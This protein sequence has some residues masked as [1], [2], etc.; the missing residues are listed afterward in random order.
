MIENLRSTGDVTGGHQY[1]ADHITLRYLD[2]SSSD[3]CFAG[4]GAD[5]D[6]GQK[7]IVIERNYIHDCGEYGIAARGNATDWIV[8]NNRFTQITEDYI[9]SSSPTGW[10]VDHNV[11]GPGDFNRPAGY[12]GHPDIWQTLDTGTNLTFTNNLVKDT[13]QSLGFI[14]G[15]T[16]GSSSGYR[17]VTI[18]NNVFARTVYGTGETCQFSAGN[19]FVFEQ[20]TMVDTQGCRWG[21]AVG[22]PWPDA[23]NLSIKR[24]ILS[25]DASFSCSNTP[26]TNTC[27]A[28]NAGQTQQCA[29]LHQLGG[30]DLLHAERSTG[31]CGGTAVPAGLRRLPVPGGLR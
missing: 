11:M 31:Q 19:D 6:A 15:P 20:N 24:N 18:T 1:P 12:S 13:N 21:S 7:H 14:F 2:V 23:S 9:Q 28:F 29:E 16:D 30:D 17:N 22:S 3:D 10:V 26:Q 8:R 4:V 5:E 27:D 25:G